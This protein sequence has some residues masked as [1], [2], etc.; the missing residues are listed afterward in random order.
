[1]GII[2]QN[3]PSMTNHAEHTIEISRFARVLEGGSI[4]KL[5]LLSCINPG[6]NPK[7]IEGSLI[8]YETQ[9]SPPLARL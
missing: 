3:I 2:A 1:M 8:G 6:A 9:L 5:M 7:V 4:R